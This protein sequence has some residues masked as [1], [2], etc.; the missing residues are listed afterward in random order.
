MCHIMIHCLCGGSYKS[1]N[2]SAIDHFRTELHM[3]W[4]EWDMLKQTMEI[5][6]L[7]HDVEKWSEGLK[8]KQKVSNED[9]EKWSEGLKLKKNKVSNYDISDPFDKA[10]FKRTS[11]FQII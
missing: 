7:E 6:T 3:K 2:K 1:D 5:N 4:N 8:L 10:P 11:K 9:L